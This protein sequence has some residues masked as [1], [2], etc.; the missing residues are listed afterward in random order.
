MDLTLV[1]LVIALIIVVVLFAVALRGGGSSRRD[2]AGSNP[3]QE[4]VTPAIAAPQGTA[5]ATSG[6]RGGAMTPEPPVAAGSPDAHASTPETTVDPGAPIASTAPDAAADRSSSQQ[7]ATRPL[8]QSSGDGPAAADPMEPTAATAAGDEEER[9]AFEDEEDEKA[10]P[11]DAGVTA[12]G[13]DGA[14]EGPA[15]AAAAGASP[16][17][18][19]L[20]ASDGASASADDRVASTA[21]AMELVGQPPR[22]G[23]VMLAVSPQRLPFRIAELQG[24]QRQLEEAITIAHRRLDDVEMG[25]DPGSAENRIRLNLLRQDLTQ[26]QERLREIL[27]L[28]DGYRWVQQ[29]MAPHPAST[30]S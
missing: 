26:K 4:A 7:P 25:P 17:R 21:A 16:Q 12:D 27:F 20:A 23:A 15:V 30:E 5:A 1:F 29:Q 24:E 6:T 11:V 22:S 14:E 3:R 8:E 18:G 13:A 9:A 10:V 28:Q 2:R 19:A